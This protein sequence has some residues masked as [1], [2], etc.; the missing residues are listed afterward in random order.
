MRI[1]DVC[2]PLRLPWNA[3]DKDVSATND[4]LH[5]EPLPDD[6]DRGLRDI[7][8]AEKISG[9]VGTVNLESKLRAAISVGQVDVRGPDP[10]MSRANQ[11]A[12]KFNL[13]TME[14]FLWRITTIPSPNPLIWRHAMNT[15]S[16]SCSDD[17]LLASPAALAPVSLWIGAFPG[18]LNPC[19]I[20]ASRSFHP[21]A[22]S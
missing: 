8:A 11:E 12:M 4:H 22:S 21:H 19:A 10:S 5:G 14:Q 9:R 6:L 7:L 15:V 1:D 3:G 20:Q 18:A 16:P 17:L 13:C 2:G